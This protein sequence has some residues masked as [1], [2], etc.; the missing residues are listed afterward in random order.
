MAK[1]LLLNVQLCGLLPLARIEEEEDMKLRMKARR[2][3]LKEL[4]V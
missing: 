4:V 3:K 2:K 1:I